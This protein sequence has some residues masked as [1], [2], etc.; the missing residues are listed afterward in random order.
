MAKKEALRELQ[1]R[2]AQRMAAVKTELP[3]RS[4]LAV[5]CAGQG[6]L[7][8][9]KQA[10]EIFEASSVMAV[11]HTQ[12]WVVGVANL[13]GGLFAVVDLAAFL[14]LRAARSHAAGSDQAR[15]VALNASLGVNSA[16]QVDRLEGLRHA[17]DLTPDDSDSGTRPA[18][19]GQRWA[20]GSGR[21]W[22]E[23]NLA[24]LAVQ[25][26]FLGIAG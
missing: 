4:W 15:L 14:G 5:E 26:Q 16:L 13:R 3:G 20:D 11:P 25:E 10:G 6:L 1:S 19:A 22:Q 21:R 8:P 24:E 9:L 2:L 12:P 18:F 7:F 23:I 17:A